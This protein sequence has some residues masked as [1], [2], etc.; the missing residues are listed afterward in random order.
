MCDDCGE[1]FVD[2]SGLAHHRARRHSNRRPRFPCDCCDMVF[3]YKQALE[4]HER[5]HTGA[6]PFVCPTCQKTFSDR[7]NFRRHQLSHLRQAEYARIIAESSGKA[8]A[9]M[10]PLEYLRLSR[11]VRNTPVAHPPADSDVDCDAEPKANTD[12]ESDAEKGNPK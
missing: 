1:A 6:R 9:K 5:I 2:A 12:S 8:A 10:T 3:H 11:K 4:T 7:S